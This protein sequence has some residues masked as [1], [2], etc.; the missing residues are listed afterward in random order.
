MLDA[1]RSRA[2]DLGDALDG[3]VARTDLRQGYTPTWWRAIGALQLLLFGAAVAGLLW[4]VV[5]W[6]LFALALP[7]FEA[8]AVG[9]LPWPTVLFVGGLLAGVVLAVV[10]RVAVTAAA[11]RHAARINR[12]LVHSV[13]TVADDLVYT[14]VLRVR[15]D[16]VAAQAALDEAARR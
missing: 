2:D 8:P 16:Y 13:A 5:R 14:P 7:S 10:A 15:D 3:A 9:R 11:R 4:L 12:R 1:A 6:V